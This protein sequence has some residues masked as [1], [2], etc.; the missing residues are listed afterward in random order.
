LSL[1]VCLV[2]AS[3]ALYAIVQLLAYIVSGGQ[4]RDR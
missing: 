2:S 1:S 3:V 4:S